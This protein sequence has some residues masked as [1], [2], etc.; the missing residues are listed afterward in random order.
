MVETSTRRSSQHLAGP[1]MAPTAPAPLKT[2]PQRPASQSC[3]R[4]RAA[5]PF[6]AWNERHYSSG[7]GG[8]HCWTYGVFR[9]QGAAQRRETP[10][11]ATL[12]AGPRGAP[13]P[14]ATSPAGR[15]VYKPTWGEHMAR[16]Y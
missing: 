2:P 4:H 12:P 6:Q 13:G 5:R 9:W 8:C 14:P 16:P 3:S 7:V 11:V 1:S 15:N 10:P